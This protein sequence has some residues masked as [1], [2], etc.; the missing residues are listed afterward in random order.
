TA[1]AEPV[2]A[3]RVLAHQREPRRPRP[4]RVMRQE[5][6]L[7]EPEARGRA[8]WSGGR[9]FRLEQGGSA[10]PPAVAQRLRGESKARERRAQVGWVARD[11]LTEPA[12]RAGP[13]SPIPQHVPEHVQCGGCGGIG[14]KR[15]REPRQGFPRTRI[16][17]AHEH[18]RPAVYG[19]RAER[20]IA[21]RGSV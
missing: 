17:Q 1:R 19:E 13:V 15:L 3:D 2:I 20:R 10:V 7:A 11:Q 14:W 12:R 8:L 6:E 5:G 4:R 21:G 16:S 18:A 9:Y